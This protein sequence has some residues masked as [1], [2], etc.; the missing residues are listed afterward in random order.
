[1]NSTEY[2][3]GYEAGH[4]EGFAAGVRDQKGRDEMARFA[5]LDEASR[6]GR[7]RREAGMRPCKNCSRPGH[8]EWV[9]DPHICPWGGN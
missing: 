5:G 7:A 8:I 3:R 4:R 6:A 9:S 2:Q 1:V